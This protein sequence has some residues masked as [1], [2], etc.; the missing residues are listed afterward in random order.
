MHA[1]TYSLPRD[2]VVEEDREVS[3]SST[4]GL[5]GDAKSLMKSQNRPKIVKKSDEMC[6]SE[7][8][9]PAVRGGKK[10]YR[11]NIPRDQHYYDSHLKE[12]DSSSS[13]RHGQDRNSGSS[14]GVCSKCNSHSR[15][16]PGS[17]SMG[18]IDGSRR[19]RKNPTSSHSKPVA[20]P[21]GHGH[22]VRKPA[23]SRSA[24][25]SY[26]T[27][28][29]KIYPR[30]EK[31]DAVVLSGVASMAARGEKIQCDRQLHVNI[32]TALV[33]QAYTAYHRPVLLKQATFVQDQP[34]Q[35]LLQSGALTIPS[36]YKVVNNSHS[37][38]QRK[39][40]QGKKKTS[41]KN[42]LKKLISPSDESKT[43]GD[44]SS[45][46]SNGKKITSKTRR[47][48]QPSPAKPSVHSNA[49][50]KKNWGNSCANQRLPDT[51]NHSSSLS[52]SSSCASSESSSSV[53]AY[54][55]RNQQ[56]SRSIYPT[57]SSIT[58][59][60]IP[61]SPAAKVRTSV[62]PPTVGQKQ[63]FGYCSTSTRRPRNMS[64]S[65]SSSFSVPSNNKK[66]SLSANSVGKPPSTSLHVHEVLVIH[67]YDWN[68]KP[69]SILNID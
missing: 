51:S 53:D 17:S 44:G 42:R 27:G 3:D 4:V 25:A 45:K 48:G 47:D 40:A 60:H 28:V 8:R 59:N 43:V 41:L 37:T 68:S 49:V 5:G 55:Q 10:V 13:N 54:Q 36:V 63:A 19:R 67:S 30:L 6:S 29:T 35:T 64:G 61:K 69:I 34:S 56:S 52:L 15:K 26:N 32:P 9:V 31:M 21:F 1:E 50:S 66:K 23:R 33:S 65:S 7:E 12:N 39:Q 46:K 57:V 22:D 38:K 58:A 24:H 18:K 2:E 20:A 62:K 16:F 14:Q 11:R